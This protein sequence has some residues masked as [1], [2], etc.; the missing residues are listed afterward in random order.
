MSFLQYCNT[1]SLLLPLSFSFNF[2]HK[3]IFG[4]NSQVSKHY[5]IEL[6]CSYHFD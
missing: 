4:K 5:Q 2:N 6:I 3:R 1:F